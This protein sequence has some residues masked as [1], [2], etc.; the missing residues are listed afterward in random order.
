LK[1]SNMKDVDPDGRGRLAP[2]GTGRGPLKM[3]AM[4]T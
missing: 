2:D 4:I 3:P 1:D